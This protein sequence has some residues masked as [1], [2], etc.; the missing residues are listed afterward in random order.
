MPRNILVYFLD[1]EIA[2]FVL[3]ALQCESLSD[4]IHFHKK[5]RSDPST[6]SF[7]AFG[8]LSTES[9]LTFY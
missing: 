3:K 7:L 5:V 4:Q 1:M 9:F 6:E 2:L 8:D